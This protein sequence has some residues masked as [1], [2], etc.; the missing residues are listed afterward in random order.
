MALTATESLLWVIEEF[1]DNHASSKA[2]NNADYELNVNTFHNWCDS[3][4]N[5][6]EKAKVPDNKTLHDLIASSAFPE[7]ALEVPS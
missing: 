1:C 5:E 7:Q 2:D 6:A 3:T 4:G